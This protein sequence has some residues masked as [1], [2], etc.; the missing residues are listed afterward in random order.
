MH[1]YFYFPGALKNVDHEERYPVIVLCLLNSN[2]HKIMTM[3]LKDT[4]PLPA[5]LSLEKCLYK[6]YMLPLRGVIFLFFVDS[7]IYKLSLINSACFLSLK[8]NVYFYDIET[9]ELGLGV[10]GAQ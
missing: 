9:Q 1:K 4:S 8:F 2:D 10:G 7:L 6:P 5:F 3:G